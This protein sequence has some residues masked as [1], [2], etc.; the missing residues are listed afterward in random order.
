MNPLSTLFFLL[1]FF[2]V[3]TSHAGDTDA[4]SN[5]KGNIT[6]QLSGFENDE[7]AIK[8]CVCRSEDEYTGKIRAFRTASTALK[9]KRAEWIFANMPYGSYN[10]K[11]FHDENG[12]NKLDTNFWG[13]PTES[14]GFSNN[15][16]GQFGPPPFSKTTFT[17]N[18]PE[19]VIEIDNDMGK[20]LHCLAYYGRVQS[21]LL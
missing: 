17:I 1:V 13:I 8:L 20:V 2:P 16:D 12:N 6:V 18:S 21:V 14:Y 5:Q 4:S 10:I 3:E 19:L 7:G 15:A 11:A 9:S